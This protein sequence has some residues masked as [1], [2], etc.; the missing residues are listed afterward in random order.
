MLLTLVSDI[1]LNITLMLEA[2]VLRNFSLVCHRTNKIVNSELFW[3]LKYQRDFPRYGDYVSSDYYLAYKFAFVVDSSHLKLLRTFDID[4]L[5][6]YFRNFDDFSINLVY[7]I[8]Y[9]FIVNSNPKEKV[10]SQMF[11]DVSIRMIGKLYFSIMY[12]PRQCANPLP[13]LGESL[14]SCFTYNIEHLESVLQEAKDVGYRVMSS[15]FVPCYVNSEETDRYPDIFAKR[16]LVE[17]EKK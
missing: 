12:F 7:P 6:H 1:L 16:P 10:L 13:R 17:H 4:L 11:P 15:G 9:Y 8:P 3:K 5:M 14:P 2:P